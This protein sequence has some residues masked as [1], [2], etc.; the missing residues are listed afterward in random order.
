MSK[1]FIKLKSGY[2]YKFQKYRNI[3]IK[4]FKYIKKIRVKKPGVR[5]FLRKSVP[6]IK[7]ILSLEI[8]EKP[9]ARFTK[10]EIYTTMIKSFNID[11][12]GK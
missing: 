2:E 11:L 6:A 12:K 4:K 5:G 7:K 10:V 3:K 9:R 8:Q 1:F